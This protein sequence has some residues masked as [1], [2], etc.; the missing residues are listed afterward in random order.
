LGIEFFGI[1]LL[2]LSGWLGGT[3]VY[4]NE[5]GVDRRYARAGKWKEVYREKKSGV[6]EVT[7]DGELEAD[8]MM[9]VHVDGKRIVL[10]KTE[11]GYAAF[12]DRCTH[13]GGSLASGT[14]ICGTVQCPWHG[15]Q[16]DVH[17]GVLKAG[18]GSENIKVFKVEIKEGK[19]FILL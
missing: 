11:N 2:V 9:L 18:P 14:L 6:M 17:T 10:A 19:V 12:E 1:G 7:K 3:L 8:Q 5:I 16:F 4:R 13:K 15:S